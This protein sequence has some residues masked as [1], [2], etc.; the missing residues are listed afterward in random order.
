MIMQ[1][2]H[3]TINCK[4][5]L[6]TLEEPRVMGI[7]NITPD[8]FYDGGLYQEERE[9]LSQAEQMLEEGAS[10]IDIGGMSTRPGSA[11]IN[12]EEELQ[13]VIS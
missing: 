5:R 4:G 3:G 12:E 9:I 13:R 2:V 10:V 7:L 1:S 11:G 8:S 6:L